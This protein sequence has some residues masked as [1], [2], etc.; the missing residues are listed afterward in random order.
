MRLVAFADDGILG[1]RHKP[2]AFGP[3]HSGKTRAFLSANLVE[4]D[5]GELARCGTPCG[6][7]PNSGC[8]RLG[9]LRSLRCLGSL[10]RYL[11]RM[12]AA[13]LR[14]TNLFCFLSHLVFPPM[15]LANHSSIVTTK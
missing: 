9:N 12:L 14:P 3:R 7:G 15:E 4:D 6:F 13:A 8:Q 11:G 5:L 1:L 10:G 2:I